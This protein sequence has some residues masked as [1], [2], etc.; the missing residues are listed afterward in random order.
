MKIIGLFFLKKNSI[1][2]C[3]EQQEL[4]GSCF[5]LEI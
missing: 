5:F 1:C 3:C 4:D 2:C